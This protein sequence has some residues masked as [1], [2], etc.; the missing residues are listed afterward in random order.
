MM[1]SMRMSGHVDPAT[2]VL[3]HQLRLDF[4]DFDVRIS[5]ANCLAEQA[6]RKLN[7]EPEPPAECQ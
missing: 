2:S 3:L 6:R 1:A 7:L 4:A 5:L